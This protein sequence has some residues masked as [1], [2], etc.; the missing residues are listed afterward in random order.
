MKLPYN[1]KR[2]NIRLLISSCSPLRN[3][4]YVFQNLKKMIFNYLFIIFFR[5]KGGGGGGGGKERR[6]EFVLCSE[7]FEYRQ[8]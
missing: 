2:C 8:K 3:A 1:K 4:F 5:K 6:I 7:M